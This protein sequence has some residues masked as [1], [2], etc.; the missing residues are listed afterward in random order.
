MTVHTGASARRVMQAA[1]PV[2]PDDGDAACITA[3]LTP[4]R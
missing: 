3:Q 4:Q 1:S 2:A